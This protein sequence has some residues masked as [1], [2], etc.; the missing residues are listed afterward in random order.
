MKKQFAV[1][2]IIALSAAACGEAK[3]AVAPKDPVKTV[4]E[5]REFKPERKVELL[6]NKFFLWKEGVTDEQVATVLANSNQVDEN[7]VEIYANDKKIAE[8]EKSAF[9]GLESIQMLASDADDAA[10]RLARVERQVLDLEERLAGVKSKA[11]ALKEGDAPEPELEIEL[12]A[13][14]EKL[15]SREAALKE[16][17]DSFAPALE[18][19]WPMLIDAHN[20]TVDE[21]SALIEKVASLEAK[22]A[23]LAKKLE[24]Q[25]L[26][27]QARADAQKELDETR[28]SLKAKQESLKAKTEEVAKSTTEVEAFPKLKEQAAKAIGDW[29]T[30]KLRN[31]RLPQENERLVLELDRNVDFF[32][33]AP[34]KVVFEQVG[35]MGTLNPFNGKVRENALYAV[36]L[37]DWDLNS[38]LADGS[39]SIRLSHRTEAQTFSS[40]NGT[41]G[42]VK[43]EP[44]GGIYRFDVQGDMVTISF[45]IARA[46]YDF[47]DGKIYYQG[48]IVVKDRFTKRVLRRGVAKLVNE[49]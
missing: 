41:V 7:T 8:I 16:A 28:E 37:A 34:T 10:D 42:P 9:G 47:V 5:L 33:G 19:Q 21:Q 49:K 38:Q 45:K 2:G 6:D 31:Y 22:E 12:A 36:T 15:A 14:K 11:V 26:A 43:Y 18:E 25:A 13:L 1:V 23:E 29:T 35:A 39:Y 27:E 4:Q 40:G 48:D 17:L 3:R 44:K 32:T 24:D 20:A 30:L 46:K